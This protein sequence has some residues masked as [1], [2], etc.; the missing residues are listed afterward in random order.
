MAH[1]DVRVPD[2]DN[3]RRDTTMDPTKPAEAGVASRNTFSYVVAGGG[4]VAAAYTAKVLVTN[5]L[6]SMNASADVLAMAKIEV[7]L[8]EIPEV[9]G[10]EQK[11]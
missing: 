9:G 5:F 11:F 6:S 1:S 2:F 8:N 10:V 7:A 3:Y 4:C